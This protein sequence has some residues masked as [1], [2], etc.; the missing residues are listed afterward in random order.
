VRKAPDGFTLVEILVALVFLVLVAV[1]YGATT[2]Y[3]SR[4]INR[5][6]TELAAQHFLETETERLR[7]VA[8]DSL[9]DGTRARGR[10]IASWWVEDSTSFRQILLE[11][12]FGSPASG[13]VVDSVTL[14]R[15]P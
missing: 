7:L 9:E 8:Y 14:F 3:A 11:T 10:G 1:S 13:F 12:R 2:Q 5:S 4:V 15:R 6:R